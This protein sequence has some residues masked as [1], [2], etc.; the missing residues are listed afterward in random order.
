MPSMLT[1][2]RC[3][4]LSIWT[5]TAACAGVIANPVMTKTAASESL[6]SRV[7]HSRFMIAPA[8]FLLRAFCRFRMRLVKTGIAGAPGQSEL[9]LTAVSPWAHK[10]VTGKSGMAT[11][12]P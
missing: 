3:D 5:T 1:A 12:A 8:R 11:S 9:I 2:M 6:A 10:T 7:F 4:D